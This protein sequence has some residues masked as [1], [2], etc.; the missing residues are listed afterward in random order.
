MVFMKRIIVKDD[1]AFLYLNRSFYIRRNI[2][3][4]IRVYGDFVISKTTE[5][6][7]KYFI[8][9]LKLKTS[10]YSLDKISREFLNYTLSLEHKKNE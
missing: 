9:K 2:E 6:G 7:D 10:N 4:T 8:V 3:E 1:F 5:I